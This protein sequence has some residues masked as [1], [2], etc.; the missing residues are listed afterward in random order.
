M[1]IFVFHSDLLTSVAR[2]QKQQSTDRNLRLPAVLMFV[3]AIPLLVAGVV[4]CIARF[5]NSS[6]FMS[7]SVD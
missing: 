4:A 2:K 3:F 5:R 7:A 1:D 6:E